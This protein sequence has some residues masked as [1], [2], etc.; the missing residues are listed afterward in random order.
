MYPDRCPCLRIRSSLMLSIKM[1]S[2]LLV[3]KAI[4]WRRSYYVTIWQVSGKRWEFV[5]TAGYRSKIQSKGF[6]EQITLSLN[7]I[8]APY[9]IVFLVSCSRWIILK[10]LTSWSLGHILYLSYQVIK[11]EG[12]DHIFVKHHKYASI[13]LTSLF[14]KRLP[15]YIMRVVA[16][17]HANQRLRVKSGDSVSALLAVSNGVR[18]GEI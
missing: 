15:K 10:A 3:K 9:S 17:S 4:Y 6:L 5:V 7:D 16:Y 2:I 8:I 18:K 1:Q 12:Y 14:S 11:H 13:R